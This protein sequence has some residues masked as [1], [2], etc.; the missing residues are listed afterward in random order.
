MFRRY[1]FIEL[2]N[3]IYDNLP[4]PFFALAP[5]DD[6][7]DVVFRQ[8]VAGCA[9]PD[10]FFT[11]FTNVDGLQSP[12]R[13]K[14][15]HRLKLAKTDKPIIAQI[16]GKDPENYYKTAKEL[17]DMGFDGI[18]INM[19]CPIKAVVNNGC[20]SALINNRPLA[21][22]IIQAVKKGAAGKVPVSVKT[23]L[24]FNEVDLTWLEFLLEQ[25][26]DAL[27]VHGRTKKEMSKAP[28]NW[29]L[30]GEVRKLRDKLGLHTKIVGNGDVDTKKQGIELA[31]K[32]KLDGIMIGRGIFS[33]PFVFSD[34]SLWSEFS[35]EQRKRLFKKHVILF[36]E[37]WQNNERHTNL[38]K[39]FC[40]I[41]IS[42]FVGAKELREKLMEA[43]TTEEL[44]TI[45]S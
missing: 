38:L 4:K 15:I 1:Y 20:C 3:N 45:L 30:I 27:T 40:K 22:E 39:K 2:M 23:R 5:L 34:N 29:E 9:K 18:D 7:T 6:V 43:K 11:E 36:A 16:W 31:N 25:G 44:V 37:T 8:I 35:A 21:G 33:D 42:D 10:L 32:Y 14:V 24:G 17:V 13:D 19:G 41:Y 12:G 28:A 26:L